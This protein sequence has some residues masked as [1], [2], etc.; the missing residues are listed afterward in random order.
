MLDGLVFD[1]AGEGWVG[2]VSV[3]GKNLRNHPSVKVVI[4]NCIF[5]GNNLKGI[6]GADIQ[7]FDANVS[8]KNSI[9]RHGRTGSNGCDDSIKVDGISVLSV[10]NSLFV[11]RGSQ[12]EP[13]IRAGRLSRVDIGFSTFVSN[14]YSQ[15]LSV[16]PETELVVKDSVFNCEISLPEKAVVQRCVVPKMVDLTGIDRFK[17]ID[18][19]VVQAMPHFV[20]TG[21]CPFVLA[22]DSPGRGIAKTGDDA[23][24]DRDMCG[25][26]RTGKVNPGCC[27]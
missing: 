16:V 8:V 9:F 7:V 20:G 24:G 13:I 26:P 23:N 3:R 27:N 6:G 14:A 5:K 10:H 25:R 19:S 1:H 18:P 4:S 12:S 11:N 2:A 15:P 17:H 22:P 21:R